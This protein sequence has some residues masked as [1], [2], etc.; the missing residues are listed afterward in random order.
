LVRL[1]GAYGIALELSHYP[2][3]NHDSAA[4]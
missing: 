3:S 1:A 4:E 2:I